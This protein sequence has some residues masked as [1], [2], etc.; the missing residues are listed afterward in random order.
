MV[1]FTNKLRVSREKLLTYLLAVSVHAHQ[2][3]IEYVHGRR[4]AGKRRREQKWASLEAT[5]SGKM[6]YIPTY[7]YSCNSN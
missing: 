3:K 5:T 1:N 2:H 7:I 4:Q 6:K